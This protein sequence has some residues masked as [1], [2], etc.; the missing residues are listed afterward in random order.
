MARHVRS[1]LLPLLLA[2]VAAS[3]SD[4]TAPGQIKVDQ[5]DGDGSHTDNNS[6]SNNGSTNNGGTNNAGTNN[7][8]LDGCGLDQC[9]IDGACVDNEAAN[10]DNPC[11]LCL[12]VADP[13]AWTPNDAATC[14]D[15]DACTTEDACVAGEC[16]GD[17]VVCN[18]ANP[19]TDDVCDSATGACAAVDN[20]ASCD[21]GDRCTLG[22]R[23]V[24]GTCM[25]GADTPTC[26][27][28][29]AC[30]TEHC[31]PSRGC[32]A[33]PADDLPCEDGDVCTEN[34]V[35]AGGRCVGGARQSCDDEDLCTVDAC[36][37]VDGCAHTSLAH[38]CADDNPCTDESC[39][40]ARGCVYPFNTNACSDG[41]ACTDGDV[42]TNGA[43]R[44]ATI[45]L[46][47]SNLC[48]DV[49]CDPDSGVLVVNNDLPCDDRDACTVGDRCADG[50]CVTG[51]E[52]LDCTDDN[53]C[54]DNHCDAATGCVMTH[55]TDPCDDGDVCTV[56]DACAGG[57]CAAGT[58]P[59]DCDDHNDCTADSC[60]PVQGCR[61]EVI[62][63]L[64]CRP[65]IQV[66]WPPRAATLDGASNVVNVTGTVD[67]GAG[68]ITRFTINGQ[69]IAVDA[70]GQ[71]LWPMD[72]R[73]G[74]NILIFEAV[75]AL[76]TS[77]KVVQSF[78]W[79]PRYR[80][81][82]IDVSKSGMVEPGV[83]IYLSQEVLDDGEHSLPADDF[84]TIFELILESF[85]I[86]ALV[87]TPNNNGEIFLSRVS[88]YDIYLRGITNDRP[89]VT[90]TT[91]PDNLHLH[92]VIDNFD[93][94][95][96]AKG[97]IF[98]YPGHLTADRIDIDADV[99][100]EVV[101][102]DIAVVVVPGSVVVNFVNVEF[103][104][105]N[106]LI[107]AVLGWLV[108]SF[109]P[110]LVTDIENDFSQ[111]LGDEL[112]PLLEDALRALAI[113]AE[114]PFP[115]LTDPNSS[116]PVSLITD[117][118]TIEVDTPGITFRMRGG[119]YAD[120]VTPWTNLGALAREGCGVAPQLL[121]VPGDDAFELVLADDILNQILWAAWLGG[122][123][124]FEVPA[125]L[126]GD[127]D[128][129]QYGVS[130]I[131][132]NASGMLQPTASDCNPDGALRLLIGDLRIDAVVVLY[133]TPVDATLFVS[134]ETAL[135]LSAGDG[136]IGLAI[137]EILS[138]DVEV[139]I[140]DPALLSLEPIFRGLIEDNLVPGLLQVLGGDTLG[141]FPLPEIDLST[142]SQGLG[143]G[144]VI[145][146]NPQHVLRL[147]G[148]TV[149]GGDLAQ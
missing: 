50:G 128:L 114:I 13:E 20:T 73:L 116:I 60:H 99:Q 46:D 1:L 120:R 105:N 4:A 65:D 134:L 137:T 93:A 124:E 16:V 3:C 10:P 52:Q 103:R 47:H 61:H 89:R 85:D 117:F 107:Q 122:F 29:N 33:E 145:R 54:T 69:P 22:D 59:L 51:T 129:S 27:D 44:G 78:L 131:S 38:L 67:S 97:L 146:I 135:D 86:F 9:E 36:D 115:S 132:L 108:N 82:D 64:E 18:D 6:T 136:Q 70:N 32:V 63:S 109:V 11:E 34:D 126:L 113:S 48:T 96:V 31:E 79:S 72:A 84:A 58:T 111:S 98:D 95:V 17:A 74:G 139:N 12:V 55:N 15:G 66:A 28:G 19:C 77:R 45:P 143:D 92:V 144:A 7:G 71:F 5:G 14:D 53:A 142:V 110:G 149:V 140:T 130:E 127:V 102:H 101:D 141:G 123:L 49:S 147:D 100:L 94:D 106:G 112:G 41:N 26:D 87:G 119:V 121:A 62:A 88:F 125:A 23:C 30:T 39:D 2:I 43:C 83:G 21:D 56:G 24:A 68:D 81:P 76:G 91:Q 57:A 35:C 104:F 118:D 37:P 80:T 25:A 148:N 75:D 40:P 133:G 42:C 90:L 8:A 138:A